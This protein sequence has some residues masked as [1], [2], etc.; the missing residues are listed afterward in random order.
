MLIQFDSKPINPE[1]AEPEYFVSGVFRARKRGS[2]AVVCS[3]YYDGNVMDVYGNDE[4]EARKSAEGI[5]SVLNSADK[6]TVDLAAANAKVAEL[7]ETINTLTTDIA[8]NMED[9][10]G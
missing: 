10:N 5:I 4:A 6:L 9:G 7:T 1:D 8:H 2:F 3:R